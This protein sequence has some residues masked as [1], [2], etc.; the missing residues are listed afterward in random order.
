MK[1]E[2]KKIKFNYPIR[3]ILVGTRWLYVLLAKELNT[4]KQNVYN[5]LS[6]ET[7]INYNNMIKYKEAFERV[8]WKEYTLEDLFWKMF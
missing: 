2:K 6:W 4:S 8:T 1:K 7:Q 5:T 3:K